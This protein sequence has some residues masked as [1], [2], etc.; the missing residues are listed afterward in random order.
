ML[1]FS[2]SSLY[3][4]LAAL[5]L[6]LATPHLFPASAV[7][8]QAPIT[9]AARAGYALI[10]GERPPEGERH[11]LESGTL[12]Q[13]GILL[14]SRETPLPKEASAP[15]ARD[16]CSLVGRYLP[17]EEHV[18]LSEET[19]YALCDLWADHPDLAVRITEGMRS[20]GEQAA[21]QRAAFASYQAAMPVAEALK[22]AVRDVPDSG[23]SEHQLATAFDIRL[24]GIQDWSYADPVA[25]TEDGRWLLAHAW[26]YGFIRRYPP[27]KAALTGVENEE[28]HFR[29]V[30]RVHAAAM[31]TAGWCLEEYLQALHTHGVLR[32]EAPQGESAWILC[33]PDA[34]DAGVSIPE[35]MTC[36]AGADNLGWIV[37]VLRPDHSRR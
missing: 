8:A 16:V 14:A 28:A 29:Y 36:E 10:A 34:E 13:G 37:C 18:S 3:M 5:S 31:Q 15:Q 33:I 23:K 7:P 30:G 19:I 26:E 12:F 35:G 1:K 24:T 9:L 4:L 6:M 27:E 22:Q 2:R 11:A 17:A 21:L 32:L 25:R 20:P